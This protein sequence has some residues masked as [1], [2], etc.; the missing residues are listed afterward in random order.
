[1]IAQKNEGCRLYG[2]IEVN[3]V[4]GNFHIAPGRSLKNAH[5]HSHDMAALSFSD[6]FNTTHVI[7][8]LSF[9]DEYEG[10]VDPLDGTAS[11]AKDRISLYQ[12]FIKI[13]PTSIIKQNGVVLETNQYSTTKHYQAVGSAHDQEKLPGVFFIYDLSPIQ[14]VYRETSQSWADYLTTIFGTAGGLFTISMLADWFF[15]SG[16]GSIKRTISRRTD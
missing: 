6:S 11:F 15:S 10:R 5:G 14:V 13:V 1:M 16:A 3:K 7:N 9:G 2:S 4:A 8:S 12:Y